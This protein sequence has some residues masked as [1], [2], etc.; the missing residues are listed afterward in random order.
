MEARFG[1]RFEI[2]DRAY[3]DRIR[4]ER[5]FS[6]NPWAS[7]PRFLI[8][9]RLLVDEDYVAPL[10]DWL[11]QG[12]N[13]SA[14][15]A[16]ALRPG[17]L[18]ILDEA[19]HA[20]P[21]SGTKYAI[22][23]KLTRALRDL[24]GRFEHRLF[25]SATPH[26]GH[27]NSFSALMELLDP[28][29]FTRGV[30]ATKANLDAT[31]VRRLKEDLRQIDGGFPER[32]VLQIDLTVPADAPELQLADLLQ[33]YRALRLQA[34][35]GQ[36]K[37]KLA[38]LMLLLSGLQQRLLSSI[39]AF[40]RTLKVHRRGVA[41]RA[42]AA[43]LAGVPI[44]TELLSGQFDPED[45]RAV[46]AG[47]E[48]AAELDA[49][50]EQ[51]SANSAELL[52]AK[53]SALLQQMTD[54]ADAARYQADARVL[55]LLSWLKQRCCAGIILPG[56]IKPS[57]IK[58]DSP[59]WQDRRVLIFTEYEDTQR[60]LVQQLRAASAHTDRSDARIKVFHGP[61]PPAT[62]EEL[63]RAFNAPPNE[64]PLRI[65][66]CTDA[67]R[68]GLNLQAFCYEMFHFDLP[69]NPSRLEQR[70]GRIDRKLQRAE[71]VYCHYFV[72]PQRVEDRVLQA[73]VRKTQSV[74]AELGSAA[75][76]IESR[77]SEMLSHGIEARSAPQLI[78]EI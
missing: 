17:T 16:K 38:E 4:R 54:I 5:G 51:A 72:Y 2:F 15:G 73:L 78:D 6:A 14:S 76:V 67:A 75:Q 23:S 62:R 1:L 39:E 30:P 26:N 44:E 9:H 37:R 18:L 40:A 8:S 34:A 12:V 53:A 31:M 41:A 20:A 47:D 25:L 42:N 46:F 77:L 64:N 24:A 43:V 56:Q 19:H 45:E 70:N 74:R 66:I 21:A 55:H 59:A 49:A 11:S 13:A 22:D 57:Q 60:Y 48:Q 63:K 33:R 10:R 69:W 68:E 50:M 27:S 32:V 61:T 52:D 58:A 7:Y 29:R 36:S 65:L 35:E 3:V 71:K 28:Y